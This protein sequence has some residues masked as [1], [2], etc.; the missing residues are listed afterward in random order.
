MFCKK[1]SGLLLSYRSRAPLSL[2][3][4]V[5]VNSQINDAV[6]DNAVLRDDSSKRKRPQPPGPPPGPETFP[7]WAYEPRPFFEFE[8]LYESKKSLARVGRIHTVSV[9]LSL[10]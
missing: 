10:I 3:S 5:D 8:L 1:A 7:S 9:D 6:Q 4:K 2:R